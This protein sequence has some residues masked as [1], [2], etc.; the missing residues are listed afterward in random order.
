MTDEQLDTLAET[1]V[2]R[3]GK[4]GSWKAAGQF[5]GQRRPKKDAHGVQTMWSILVLD[6]LADREGV[7]RL[8]RKPSN[9]CGRRKQEQPSTHEFCES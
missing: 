3:Q 4:D 5:N 7:R 9:G 8:V 2:G 6:R 1:I